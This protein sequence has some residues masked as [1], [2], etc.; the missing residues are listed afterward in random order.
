VKEKR[1]P[2]VKELVRCHLRWLTVAEAVAGKPSGGHYNASSSFFLS[3]LS[4][5]SPLYSSLLSLYSSSF[6]LFLSAFLPLQKGFPCNFNFLP[7]PKLI[8]DTPSQ[9]IKKKRK[10]SELKSGLMTALPLPVPH[11]PERKNKT[12]N[13]Q[14]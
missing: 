6:F 4:S 12:R 11:A 10:T 14:L 8:K 5:L 7:R 9:I 2:G 13:S 3:V 1:L